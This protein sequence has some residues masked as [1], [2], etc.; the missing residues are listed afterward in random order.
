[1]GHKKA[2]VTVQKIDPDTA[3]CFIRRYHYSKVLPRLNKHFLGIYRDGELSGVVTLGWGTQPLQT[4][5]KLFPRHALL[6]AHYLEIG[7]MCFLPSEN[8]NGYFGSLALSAL[9]KWVREHTGCLFLYTLADG[10]MGK[11]GYVYQAANFRYLGSFTTSVYRDRETGEKIHPRSTG[12]LLLE[13][14]AFDGVKKRHWL[15]YGFCESKG[16]DKINGRMF[17]YIYPLTKKA[18]GILAQYPEYQKLPHPKDRDLYFAVRV[19]DRQYREIP[20]PR[21]NRDA[22]RYNPQQFNS[23]EVTDHE[24]V[25]SP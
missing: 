10:I 12:K 19:G 16:I 8:G 11:C 9:I 2:A 1:M 6:T 5:Q 15:T 18:K 20:P 7:K 22:H 25:Q 21:F 14:A 13:N 24:A 17:R 23:L 3:V 4:I